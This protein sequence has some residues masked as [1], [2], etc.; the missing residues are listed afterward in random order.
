MQVAPRDPGD[1][2]HLGASAVE[3]CGGDLRVRREDARGVGV[4]PTAGGSAWFQP[5]DVLKL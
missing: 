5:V 2:Q 4:E 3:T 1:A